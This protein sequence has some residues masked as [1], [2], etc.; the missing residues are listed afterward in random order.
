METL[1]SWRVRLSFKNATIFMT[2]LNTITALFLLQGFLSS[3]SSRNSKLSP[4]HSN[5]VKLSYIKESEEMRLATQP[6]KLIKRVKEIE[7]E[8]HA[9]PETVQ[10]KDIKQTAAADLSKR[11][12]DFRSLNNA[13][14]LKALDEWRKRKMERARQWALEKNGTITS[15]A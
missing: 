10:Q 11:L 12:Q 7:Q 9:G 14:S 6:W 2:L 5:S 8:V 13:S 15:Q 1:Q 4:D 3:P